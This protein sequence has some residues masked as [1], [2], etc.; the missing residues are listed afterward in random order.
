MPQLKHYG[1]R[2]FFID[3]IAQTIGSKRDINSATNPPLMI[4]FLVAIRSSRQADIET[5]KF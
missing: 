5:E 3:I 1:V 4:I 2:T